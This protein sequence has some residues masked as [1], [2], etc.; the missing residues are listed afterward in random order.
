[1]PESGGDGQ[2]SRPMAGLKHVGLSVTVVM[3][4]SRGRNDERRYWPWGSSRKILVGLGRHWWV[5]QGGAELGRQV[6]ANGWVSHR[7]RFNILAGPMSA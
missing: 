1:M 6:M 3:I 5:G 7:G 2:V 4:G